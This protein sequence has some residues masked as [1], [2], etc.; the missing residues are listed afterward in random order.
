[1]VALPQQHIWSSFKR[2]VALKG[3]GTLEIRSPLLL[4]SS[5][6][7]FLY[8]ER[9]PIFVLRGIKI[10]VQISFFSVSF[11]LD[12]L[13]VGRVHRV[14]CLPT[15][16]CLRIF[17]SCYPHQVPDHCQSFSS[18]PWQFLLATMPAKIYNKLWRKLPLFFYP[19]YCSLNFFFADCG[20]LFL[21]HCK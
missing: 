17:S 2:G 1:M 10:K 3:S 18:P 15:D 7:T 13:W 6:G 5:P 19:W 4:R 16:R 14:T 8:G 20:L 11:C 12:N 21:A 9:M